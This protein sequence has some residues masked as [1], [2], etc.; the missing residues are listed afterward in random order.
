MVQ[1][2][3]EKDSGLRQAMRTMGLLESSY[4]GSWIVFDLSFGTVLSL[5]IIGS[6]GQRADEQRGRGSSSMHACCWQCM[7][8]APSS[9]KPRDGLCLPPCWCQAQ[10]TPLCAPPRHPCP[11][12]VLRFRFFLANDFRLLFAL[13]W[14]FLAAIS[15]FI[16]FVSAF[17]RKPQAAVYVGFLVFLVSRGTWRLSACAPRAGRT[18]AC[19]PPGRL[20]AAASQP[21]RAQAALLMLT[22]THHHAPP[23]S[24]AAPGRL[25]VPGHCDVRPAV[26][27]AVLL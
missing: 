5:A 7:L 15:G 1:L 2:V 9:K 23:P 11:G 3:T 25:D 8:R 16:Y 10:R 13:F 6:G 26:H 17:V 22:R 14:L 12:M 24:F 19:T 21:R 4:W 27:A 20:P 18:S